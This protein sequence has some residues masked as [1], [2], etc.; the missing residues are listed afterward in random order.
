MD[1]ICSEVDGFI[2]PFVLVP[3]STGWRKRRDVE[4]PEESWVSGRTSYQQLFIIL[5]RVNKD[6]GQG[7]GQATPQYST[8]ALEAAYSYAHQTHELEYFPRE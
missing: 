4:V 6:Q 2:Q 8:E 7:R 3:A 5:G 1:S